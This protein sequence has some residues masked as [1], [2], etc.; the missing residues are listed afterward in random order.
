[1]PPVP[2]I[3]LPPSYQF[4]GYISQVGLLPSD[5]VNQLEINLT[6]AKH[7]APGRG[8]YLSNFSSAFWS[9]RQSQPYNVFNALGYRNQI[10][11]GFENY[12]IEGSTFALN[13]AT[14]KRKIFGRSWTI[15]DM[16]IE[17]FSYFPL[18]VYFKAFGDLGYVENYPYYDENGLN[19][20]LSNRLLIGAGL[21]LDFVTVYD[22]VLRFEY[23]FTQQ[24]TNG[25]FFFN[26]KKEF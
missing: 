22:L 13:K 11:R 18:A 9:T 6:Y 25:A 14:I 12:V 24:K 19:K 17:Q 15:D 5:D 23:T 10:V 2:I 26:L 16:P 1:M 4:T 21:G 7:W 3:L 8:Y 20:T